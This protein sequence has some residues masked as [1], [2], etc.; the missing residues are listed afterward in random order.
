MAMLHADFAEAFAPFHKSALVAVTTEQNTGYLAIASYQ[1]IAIL[2]HALVVT[3]TLNIDIEIGTS[4]AG[5]NAHTLKSAT[6]R[7]AADD[8]KLIVFDIRPDELSN[9][10]GTA[11]REFTHLNVEVTPDGAATVSV[12]VLGIPAYAPADQTL[13]AEAVS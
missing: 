13:W 2:I 9:P 12:I 10:S 6:Q 8:N 5:A 3:T 4:A 7:V 11:I 1:R